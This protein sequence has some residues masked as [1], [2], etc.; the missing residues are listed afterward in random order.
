MTPIDESTIHQTERLADL[1]LETERRRRMAAP[2]AALV[3]SANALSRKMAA[4][5]LMAITPA[6]KFTHTPRD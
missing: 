4:R 3:E 2:F 5:A 6:T 1:P